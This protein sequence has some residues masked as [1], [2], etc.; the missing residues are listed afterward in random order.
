[1]TLT[2]SDYPHILEENEDIHFRLRCRQLKE[3][4]CRISPPREKKSTNGKAREM[5]T[6]DDMEI[7]EPLFEDG[8]EE[9]DISN[10][11]E[12]RNEDLDRA[13]S[14]THYLRNLFNT[15]NHRGR[16]KALDD[17][18]SLITY[19]NPEKSDPYEEDSRSDLADDLN[20][21]ILGTLSA[22]SLLIQLANG[23]F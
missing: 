1:M 11:E 9:M 19:K 21:A 23:L 20:A 17:A 3:M 12:N 10:N 4:V 5:F 15:Q 18:F 13:V 8:L 16:S 22:E 7:D 14:F 2:E 6:P